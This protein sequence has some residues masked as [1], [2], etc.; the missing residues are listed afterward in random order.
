CPVTLG[1]PTTSVASFPFRATT[2]PIWTSPPFPISFWTVL[3]RC[4]PLKVPSVTKPIDLP[5]PVATDPS[6]PAKCNPRPSP[7]TADPPVQCVIESCPSPHV[8]E[9]TRPFVPLLR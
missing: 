3:V 1:P 7:G 9:R 5:G 2:T 4:V 6:T 8:V